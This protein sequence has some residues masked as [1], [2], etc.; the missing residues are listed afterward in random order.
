M[1]KPWRAALPAAFLLLAATL[2]FSFRALS[3]LDTLLNAL[4]LPRQAD[5]L[6][7]FV[8][9]HPAL[10]TEIFPSL[11]VLLACASFALTY[12]WPNAVAALLRRKRVI[13]R[14]DPTIPG[15][16]IGATFTYR[17]TVVA[18][19]N[20]TVWDADPPPERWRCFR[21]QLEPAGEYDVPDCGGAVVSIELADGSWTYHDHPI[22]LAIA[23]PD[24]PTS[25]L[26]HL[27]ARVPEYLNVF[28][29]TD[30]NKVL[31]LGHPLP[32]TTD[33]ESPFSAPGTFIFELVVSAPGFPSEF[34]AI[35]LR[36]TGDWQTA[37]AQ[38]WKSKLARL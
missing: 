7:D 9:A 4:A 33:F 18:P 8:G 36:W 32:V 29:V 6:V 2:A 25:H 16:V 34:V 27:R 21:V 31:V 3:M 14:F 22:A 24:R 12:I 35:L 37:A 38:P 1:R 30:H 5:E 28:A 10:V 23:P 20:I 11:L 15:C 26:K 13:C 19:P 17:S